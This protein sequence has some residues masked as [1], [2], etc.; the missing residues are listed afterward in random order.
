MVERGRQAFAPCSTCHAVSPG[1]MSGLGPNLHGVYGRQAGSEEGFAYS[2][3]L[4]SSGIV[5]RKGALDDF[6]A[7]PSRTVQ[8]TSMIYAGEPDPAVR[9]AIIAY[10]QSLQ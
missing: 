6:I 2:P 3:E 9:E 1:E 8:G 4:A 5:W 10:L 7:S